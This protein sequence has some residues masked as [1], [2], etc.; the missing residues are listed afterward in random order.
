M[1]AMTL[2]HTNG[3]T[4]LTTMTAPWLKQTAR[5]FFGA[6]N[7]DDNPPEVQEQKR[8]VAQSTEQGTPEPLSLLWSVSQFFN[9]I[10]WDDAAI[11]A[12]SPAPSIEGNDLDRLQKFTLDDFA[13]LF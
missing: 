5:E 2:V 9:T 12:P 13:D 6:I 8:L 1:S 4:P 7:W 3:S 10:N 11:A